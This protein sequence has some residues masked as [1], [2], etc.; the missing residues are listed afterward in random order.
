MPRAYIIAV[1]LALGAAQAAAQAPASSQL[2]PFQRVKAEALLADKLSCL[3][4]HTLHGKG[5]RIGPDLSTVGARLD[6]TAIRR[7]IQQPRALMPRIPLP[8]A[9]LDLLVAYLTEQRGPTGGEVTV[10]APPNASGS[11]AQQLYQLRCS[12]CHGAAGKGDGPNARYLDRPP[13]AHADAKQMSARTDDRLFDAIHAGGA[14]MGGSPR[15]PPFGETLSAEDIRKLVRHI[16]ALC[17]CQQPA[18]AD[19]AR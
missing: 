10:A 17:R 3:G 16:R 1:A 5:G 12:S 8:S 11:R 13:A 2:S 18:W 14:I 7:Q 19:G 4:C 9:T 6:A 15:M